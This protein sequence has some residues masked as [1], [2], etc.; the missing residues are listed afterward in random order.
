MIS[1]GSEPG[2]PSESTELTSASG[3]RAVSGQ[4][5]GQ[6]RH[7]LQHLLVEKEIRAGVVAG[8]QTG[9]G[10]FAAASCII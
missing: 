1:F 5:T 6:L 10:A 2:Q 7:A 9:V 8:V 3:L 4:I